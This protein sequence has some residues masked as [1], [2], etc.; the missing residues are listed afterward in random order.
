MKKYILLLSLFCAE[1]AYAQEC[2]VLLHGYLRNSK[3]MQPIADILD[4]SGY[5]IQNIS[6]PSTDYSIQTLSRDHVAPQIDNSNCEKIHF[7][8]HSMGG[9]VA[10]QYLADNKPHNLG[11]VILIAAPNNGSELIASLE[12]NPALAWTLIGPAARDLSPKSQFLH[13]LPLPYYNTGII[14]A[15]KSINPITSIFLFNS[16]NDGTLT[17]E[18]MKIHN[19]TDIINLEATHT[20]VLLHPDIGWQIESFLKYGKFIRKVSVRE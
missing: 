18:S 15:N 1:A 8:G 12:D 4:L 7:I 16:P 10:R 5:K 13:E 3:C 14:T 6:Y 2:V 9:I 19:M 11:N 20:M 17:V